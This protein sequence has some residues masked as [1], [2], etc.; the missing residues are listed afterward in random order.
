[1]NNQTLADTL[2]SRGISPTQ[3]RLAVYQY[4]LDHRTH[5]T[6]DTV[7]QALVA[8]Y[9]TISRTTVYNTMRALF[10][11]GLLRIVTI[12]AEEQHFD[13]DTADHGHFRCTKCGSLFDFTLPANASQRLA[14]NGYH[15]EIF[16][17]Y[18]T[19]V[20]PHCQSN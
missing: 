4:L 2:R 7:Y 13:A 8:E 5:P 10:G 12:D 3:Q 17:V 11:A 19:G 6:A 9:P 16:D 20:C 18:A 1:M 15:T 14:P